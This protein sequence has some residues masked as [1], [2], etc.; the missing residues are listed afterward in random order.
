MTWF[1]S[2]Y[3]RFEVERT[4]PVHDLVAAIPH[5]TAASAMDLG[6]GP[7]NSTEV[8]QARFPDATVVGLDSS[9]D[10]IAAARAR[11]PQVRFELGDIAAWAAQPGTFDIVLANAA[12]QWVPDHATL[13]PALL[14]R[15]APGGSLAVQVPDNLDE[16][17]H[18]LMREVAAAGPWAAKLARAADAR[19]P[20]HSPA[21]YHRTLTQ[22]GADVDIWRTTYFHH[23]I[24]GASGIVEWFRSTGLRPF[25]QPLDEEERAEF[26]RRY[27][28]AL[29]KAYPA[30]PG[31][32]V[33]LPFPR[34]FFVASRS[35][36]VG[37]GSSNSES[38]R[39]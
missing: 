2:Q 24:D 4:R 21:S 17:A 11:L 7:G 15:V 38:A 22:A 25:V 32:G 20:R 31:G 23:L 30:L 37:G 16:P 14:G 39:Q 10:M 26:L 19:G 3:S 29:A 36:G 6:C 5:A 12:L 34:L 33:L 9:S 13:L 28:A 1:P 18:V 8:L 27:Q 35:A